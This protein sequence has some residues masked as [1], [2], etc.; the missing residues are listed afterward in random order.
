M[1]LRCPGPPRSQRAAGLGGVFSYFWSDVSLKD[2]ESLFTTVSLFPWS[3]HFERRGMPL[4]KAL[5]HCNFLETSIV[6]FLCCNRFSREN[7]TL[8]V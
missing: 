2:M 1:V 3:G 4:F 8:I 7:D 6:I 5:H